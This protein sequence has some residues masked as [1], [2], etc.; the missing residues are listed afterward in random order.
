M[1]KYDVLKTTFRNATDIDN[2]F[3]QFGESSFV[4]WWNK[5]HSQKGA[6]GKVEQ[7]GKTKAA[8]GPI[9]D[10]NWRNVWDNLDILFN[11]SE[12]NLV[13]F[14]CLNTIIINE[15]TSFRPITE[16][17]GNKSFPGISYTYSPAN[18]RSYNTLETNKTAY[19]LFRD[20]KYVNAHE[21]LPFSN[22]KFTNDVTWQ[23]VNF[24]PGTSSKE[25]DG[26]KPTFL[27]EADFHKY[28]GRGFIQL[29]GRANYKNVIKFIINYKGNNQVINKIKNR[30]KSVAGDNI[31][32][33]ATISTNKE[34]D[35][36]F[37]DTDN[38]I[39]NASMWL[40]AE[41][42]KY[43]W[44]TVTNDE[45]K[46][47]NDI[48]NVAKK[49]AGNGAKFYHNVYL[50]RI[51]QQL[52]MIMGGDIT[53]TETVNTQGSNNETPII[54]DE[55]GQEARRS[56]SDN[57]GENLDNM[58]R[59]E[60]LINY[61]KPKS[62]IL[63]DPIRIPGG[64]N[65]KQMGRVANTLG[66]LP[67]VYYNGIQIEN[68]NI[69]SFSM[70]VEEFLPRIKITFTDEYGILDNLG[71]PLDDTKITIFINSR[72]KA[73]KSILMRFKIETY[74]KS[75]NTYIIGGV[76]DVNK[77]FLRRFESYSNMT[78]FECLQEFAKRAGLGFNSNISNSNDKMTWINPGKT[79]EEFIKDVV[80]KSYRSDSSFIWAYVDAYYNLNYIDVE[81]ALKV[82]VSKSIGV[83]T[84]GLHT[85]KE[86]KDDE[87]INS[88]IL[89]ND[90]SLSS[91][92]NYF[93]KFNLINNSTNISLER[94]YLNR[95]K[96]FDINKLDILVFDI[97]SITSEGNKHIILKGSPQ[98][99]KYFREHVTTTYTG[100]LDTDNM[101][102]NY[103]YSIV[104]NSQNIQELQKI[105]VRIDMPS[106]NLNLYRF[107]KV[108]IV[109][110]NKVKTPTNPT[111]INERLT[112]EWMVVDIKYNQIENG[113]KQIVTLVRRDLSLTDEEL[114]KGGNSKPT[115][116]VAD[117]VE[118][119]TN[120]D[121]AVE[122]IQESEPI[123][124]VPEEEIPDRLW[125]WS[126]EFSNAQEID[127]FFSKYNPNGFVAWFTDTFKQ[128]N[129][130]T[131][132]DVSK[133]YL[134][135]DNWTK[136]WNNI[137][138]IYNSID[139]GYSPFKVENAPKKTVN[140]IEF[141]ALNS[142]LFTLYN[143]QLLASQSMV[144]KSTLF[145]NFNTKP[146]MVS[147]YKCFNNDD[148]INAHGNKKNAKALKE[149]MDNIWDTEGPVYQF[150]IFTSSNKN[151]FTLEADFY[152]FQPNGYMP[153]VGRD[154]FKRFFNLVK[155]YDGVH[156]FINEYKNKWSDSNLD[157]V[158]YIS[159][160]DDIRKI[161][162]SDNEI[163]YGMLGDFFFRRNKEHIIDVERSED[164]VLK[165]IENMG[166]ALIDDNLKVSFSDGRLNV[167]YF[168]KL[169]KLQIEILDGTN[170]EE[171]LKQDWISG[172][173]L[174]SGSW[175]NSEYNNSSLIYDIRRADEVNT[176]DIFIKNDKG[177]FEKTQSYHS[178]YGYKDTSNLSTGKEIIKF[179]IIL[180]T[181]L[182]KR[183][184]ETVKK[185]YPFA[186]FTIEIKEDRLPQ[187][188]MAK[189]EVLDK[190]GGDL[191]FEYREIYRLTNIFDN[192]QSYST[193]TPIKRFNE[194]IETLNIDRTKKNYKYVFEDDDA[195][196]RRVK[197]V[198]YN[199][200]VVFTTVWFNPKKVTD[201]EMID[202]AMRFTNDSFIFK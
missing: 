86:F 64:G 9:K 56:T 28:R 148:Y 159:E 137:I 20:S 62:E 12:I 187:F 37:M 3:K 87:K 78:S 22:Y 164:K 141:I 33:I 160:M 46:L 193:Q 114:K 8:K 89:T 194:F 65:K 112:G 135:K 71:I 136:I 32:H 91:S 161:L 195:K 169:V 129:Q 99:E 170:M 42:T 118:E 134:N 121:D 21:H 77:M 124:E 57:N 147:A 182:F 150:E 102:K 97:D 24:P 140:A 163:A 90:K 190:K 2:F 144:N 125:D 58:P 127:D 145:K 84:I 172:E 155:N 132:N 199:G 105:A 107:Q 39:A 54:S 75:G 184:F 198:D 11:K 26:K 191:F 113:F 63:P 53:P 157:K 44:I 79:G 6:F 61:F 69:I 94:G 13:E 73:L 154:E 34:W 178:L 35:D 66:Y 166:K 83:D 149:T 119:T 188:N 143:K 162:Y 4:N 139:M 15:A 5:N 156:T 70:S 49:I 10:K 48:I 200:S 176:Y 108:N 126:I 98:D 80:S 197:V 110:S 51:L 96:F 180:D 171:L 133:V 109:F 116:E 153:L 40:H 31:D 30:W 175:F 183:Y 103:N 72:S 120:P 43:S 123:V 151:N 128:F 117:V 19:D 138:Y 130:I 52:N 92:N 111:I 17:F 76:T 181:E 165:S 29:T 1:S 67:F 41:R 101:H 100:K 88:L 93:E 196:K 192:Y 131:N 16:F 95:V 68:K 104:Q 173:S 106:P 122:F 158:A 27:T 202:A 81:D 18:K 142:L 25:V 174:Q 152:K 47:K 36:L 74:S 38:I 167:D 185:E 189:F 59:V 7:N 82:D 115:E 168:M 177:E 201:Q 50:N 55:D 179:E 186:Q 45:N 146:F 23:T 85:I 60:G 14:I